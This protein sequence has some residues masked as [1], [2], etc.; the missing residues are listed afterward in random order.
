[1][2]YSD[3]IVYRYLIQNTSFES[4]FTIDTENDYLAD[5]SKCIENL[6]N[7]IIQKYLYIEV[8][9]SANYKLIIAVVILSILLILF[10]FLLLREKNCFKKYSKVPKKS[11]MESYDF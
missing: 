7:E 6:N 8:I 10:I 11:Q 5:Y 1:M 9:D 2:V 3:S 4:N